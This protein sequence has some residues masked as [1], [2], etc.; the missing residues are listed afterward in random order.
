[1]V[2][3]YWT[4]HKLLGYSNNNSTIFFLV[5]FLQ[6]SG[7]QL[8]YYSGQELLTA[9]AWWGTT[10]ASPL[11]LGMDE[12][13]R[14]REDKH[15][16]SISSLLSLSDDCSFLRFFV[17]RLWL[18]LCTSVF[19]S[20]QLLPVVSRLFTGGCSLCFFGIIVGGCQNGSGE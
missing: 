15:D 11:L 18:R 2:A 12:G 7:F 4:G 10:R 5:A 16:S 1:M 9:M 8:L 13:H 17:L 3:F 14:F 19:A 6:R 20:P